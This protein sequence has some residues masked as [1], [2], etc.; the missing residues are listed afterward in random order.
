MKTD[1]SV[2]LDNCC[3]KARQRVQHV[4]ESLYLKRPRTPCV[5]AIE[6]IQCSCES[7]TRNAKHD[8]TDIWDGLAEMNSK[9]RSLWTNI[10][11]AGCPGDRTFP[12]PAPEVKSANLQH[13][14]K[15]DLQVLLGSVHGHGNHL[16][17]NA[18]SACESRRSKTRML[19]IPAAP[20][21]INAKR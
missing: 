5:H 1:K 7:I 20:P 10:A 2:P 19:E 17:S 12:A 15:F 18:F 8:K 9:M 6:C 13:T 11:G 14:A 3:D 16:S 21:Q 4:E